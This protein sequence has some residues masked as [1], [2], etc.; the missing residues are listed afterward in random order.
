MFIGGDRYIWHNEDWDTLGVFR[1]RWEPGEEVI[2]LGIDTPPIVGTIIT[3][4]YRS[5]VMYITV[6]A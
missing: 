1:I 6:S 5:C 3:A 2:G 4:Q